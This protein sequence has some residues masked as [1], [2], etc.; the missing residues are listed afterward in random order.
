MLPRDENSEGIRTPTTFVLPSASTATQAVRCR[1]DAAAQSEHDLLKSVLSNVVASAENERLIDFGDVRERLDVMQFQRS[2]VPHLA[3]QWKLRYRRGLG[4]TL[5]AT[6]WIAQAL[7]ED[8]FH[9]EIHNDQV[10]FELL[11]ADEHLTTFVQYEAVAVEH[12]FVLSADKIVVRNDDRVVG[13][14]RLQHAFAPLPLSGVVGRRRNVDQDFSAA[15]S[16]L[17]KKWSVRI[18]DVFA[19]ADSNRCISDPEYR[20]R[21]SRLKVTELIEDS[22]VRQKHLVIDRCDLFRPE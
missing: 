11:A 22:V 1:I 15:G 4:H 21:S 6:A 14:P 5:L 2:T 10:F 17:M 16:R 7:T 3:R 12:E 18:P 9:I 20:T 8:R 13:R 19:D